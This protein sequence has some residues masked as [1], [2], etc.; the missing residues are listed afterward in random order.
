MMF[1][2][3]EYILKQTPNLKDLFL[4]GWYHLLDAKK[5]EILLSMHCS[6]LIKLELICTD[7]IY[8]DTFDQLS[9]DFEKECKTS[10]F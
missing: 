4:W 10:V 8:D 7:P 1:E 5:W 3:I 2:H 9:D 6:K